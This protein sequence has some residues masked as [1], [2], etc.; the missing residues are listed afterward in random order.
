MGKM[1]PAFAAFLA[2]KKKGK[3]EDKKTP[4]VKKGK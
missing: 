3:T 1:P 4:P 2:K